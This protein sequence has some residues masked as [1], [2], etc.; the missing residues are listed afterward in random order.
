M[1]ETSIVAKLGSYGRSAGDSSRAFF[2]SITMH[3][4]VVAKAPLE[5]SVADVEGDHARRVVLEQ[6]VGEAADGGADVEAGATLHLDPEDVEGA[7][8]LEAAA[9]DVPGRGLDLELR[10]VGHELAGLRRPPTAAP[11]PHPSGAHRGRCTGA[12]CGQA[13]LGQQ[14]VDPAPLH[15]ANG[16]W[17]HPDR[18]GFRL[19]HHSWRRRHSPAAKKPTAGSST[20]K[21]THT[22]TSARARPTFTA[23]SAAESKK[24]VRASGTPGM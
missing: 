5:L 19:L 16:T 3:P 23:H 8:E 1:N 11:H 15:G 22:E 9:G 17:Q 4:G 10:V 7:L 2:R 13:A 14:G 21:R 20:T 24:K 18:A 12:R 6:A